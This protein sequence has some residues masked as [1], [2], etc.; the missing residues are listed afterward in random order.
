MFVHRKLGEKFVEIFFATYQSYTDPECVMDLLLK[1]FYFTGANW[2]D[3]EQEYCNKVQQNVLSLARHW[4][5]SDTRL[6]LDNENLQRK[7]SLVHLP[8]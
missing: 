3:T 2:S 7:L 5:Q 1:R 6:F 8:N 4:F